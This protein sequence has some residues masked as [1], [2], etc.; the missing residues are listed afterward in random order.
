MSVVEK[1]AVTSE[2]KKMLTKGV[3]EVTTPEQDQ[4]LSNVFVRPKPENKHRMIL[5]LKELNKCV[6]FLHFKME[7]LKDIKH[8]LQK[9][10]FLIKI[11]LQD[12]FWS[13][14]VSRA[15]RK[16]M[17]FEWENTLYEFRTLAFGLGPAPWVFTKMMKIPISLMR[18]L[19]SRLMIFLDDM[20]LAA[21]MLSRSIPGQ[22]HIDI[23]PRKSRSDSELRKVYSQTSSHPRVP[24]HD[25]Q[26]IVND[27]L[28][29]REKNQGTSESLRKETRKK[30]TLI[31]G[32]ESTNRQAVL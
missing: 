4:F 6:R 13:V 16:L 21:Q 7:N 15:S 3:V 32:N 5:N 29:H 2:I 31:E 11:D 26:H 1:L 20:L 28:S 24:G 17:R 23:S 9:G 12:A 14:P 30:G 18:K 22:R 10:D 19:G 8:L 27:H 25:N